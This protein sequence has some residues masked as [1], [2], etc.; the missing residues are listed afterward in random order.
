MFSS[1]PEV[2]QPAV[3]TFEVK[4]EGQIVVIRAVVGS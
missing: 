2:T 1:S 3:A 4:L